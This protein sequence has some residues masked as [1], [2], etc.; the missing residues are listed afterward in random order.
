[1]CKE[2]EEEKLR[3]AGALEKQQWIILSGVVISEKENH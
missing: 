3:D 2:K 1:M